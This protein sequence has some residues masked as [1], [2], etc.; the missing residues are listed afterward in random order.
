MQLPFEPMLLERAQ[1][2][3]ADANWLYQ[4]KWDGV[5]N[6][7]LVEAGRVR[8]WSRRLRDRTA[9]FPELDGLGRVFGPQRVVLDGEIIVLRAGKPNF[10]AILERDVGSRSPEP[11]KVTQ[12]PAVFMVFDL[13][14]YGGQ[15][16]YSRPL[17]ERLELL[18][19]LLAPT[20]HWQPVASFPGNQGPDLFQAVVAQAMEGVVAKRLASPYLVGHR[21]RDWLKIKRKQQ[22]LAV[23]CGYHYTAG[24]PGGLLLGAYREGQL[25]YIGRAGSGLSGGDLDLLKANL[26]PG[27]CPFPR[28]PSLRDRFLGVPGEV[29]WTTPRLTLRVQFT[30]WTE[31]MRLRDPVIMGFA[32]EPP[33]AAVIS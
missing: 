3:F 32:T 15:E 14:E 29:V 7:A 27:P 21:S 25:R 9:L 24:R 22:M 19:A 30:E 28:L 20:D 13:L 16:L 26:P 4:V 23:V 2:P 5:R 18:G 11:R 12:L 31:E 8:H 1:A 6:L 10:A 17:T 33:E